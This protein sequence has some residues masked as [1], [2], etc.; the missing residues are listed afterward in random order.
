MH[1]TARLATINSVVAISA[2]I[3]T[4][5]TL[6]IEGPSK[7]VTRESVLRPDREL[8][9]GETKSVLLC[10][11]ST[12]MFSIDLYAKIRVVVQNT[13]L[14][15]LYKS[16]QG[17]KLP[18]RHQVSYSIQARPPTALLFSPRQ[19]HHSIL[20]PTPSIL[21]PSPPFHPFTLLLPAF[22]GPTNTHTHPSDASL[23]QISCPFLIHR[24]IDPTTYPPSSCN[25]LK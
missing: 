16:L 8:E 25:P 22:L 23:S 14:V 13:K 4:I 5:T 18:I 3:M 19:S 24:T 9:R 2:S 17:G 11:F 21:A 1:Q 6:A 15:Y 10:Q 12:P 20:E 7:Q